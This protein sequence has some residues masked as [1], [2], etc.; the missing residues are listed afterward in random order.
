MNDKSHKNSEEDRG[1][2]FVD[3]NTKLAACFQ[4]TQETSDFQALYY[5]PES[6]IKALGPWWDYL[7]YLEGEHFFKKIPKE[8]MK[9][10]FMNQITTLY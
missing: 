2:K 7:F 6:H 9:E 1:I 8:I 4:A 5:D 10:I 3:K